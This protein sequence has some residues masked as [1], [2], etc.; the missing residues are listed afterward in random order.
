MRLAN[1]LSK[2]VEGIPNIETVIPGHAD[3]PHSWQDLVDYA[4]FYNDLLMQVEQGK[5][6]GHSAAQIVSNYSLPDRYREFQ[7]PVNRLEMIVPLAL[8]GR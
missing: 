3:D 4:G 1:Q 7:A 8:E 2:A 6:A 5:A